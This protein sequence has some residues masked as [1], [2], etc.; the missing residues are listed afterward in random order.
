MD[1]YKKEIYDSF[2]E[3]VITPICKLTENE[4]RNQ[5]HQVMI[6]NLNQ[7]NPFQQKIKDLS[8]YARMN[9][10]YLF[11]KQINMGYEI[12]K[13]LSSVFYEMTALSPHDFC[14]YEQMR[15]LA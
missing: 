4:L 10:L 3:T 2:A 9:D 11:E 5:I 6:P 7:V 14:T 13:Y 1:N 12:K 8:K 15:S